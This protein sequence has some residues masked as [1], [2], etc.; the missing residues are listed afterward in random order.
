MTHH[1]ALLRRMIANLQAFFVTFPACTRASMKI[2]CPHAT[3]PPP[4]YLLHLAEPAHRLAGHDYTML[5]WQ[6]VLTLRSLILKEA[7][8]GGSHAS[9]MLDAW[10]NISTLDHRLAKLITDCAARPEGTNHVGILVGQDSIGYHALQ[11]ALDFHMS[12]K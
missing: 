5:N 1:E 4:L 2:L 10:S 9:P 3:G 7:A 8:R 12:S 6:V 11:L